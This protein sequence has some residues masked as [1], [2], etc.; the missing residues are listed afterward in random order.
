[1]IAQTDQIKTLCSGTSCQGKR[2]IDKLQTIAQ[3]L[4]NREGLGGKFY[5]QERDF[6]STASRLILPVIEDFLSPT[7]G[8]PPTLATVRDW[9]YAGCPDLMIA[10]LSHQTQQPK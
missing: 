4:L 8:K 3:E 6:V 5:P 2:N 7:G 10:V 1:M 9:F